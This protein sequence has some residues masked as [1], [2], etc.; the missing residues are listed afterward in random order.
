MRADVTVDVDG[1]VTQSQQPV[2]RGG[3]IG[4]R[5]AANA[6]CAELWRRLTAAQDVS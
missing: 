1:I 6:A 2:F 5:R 4:Q 3:N